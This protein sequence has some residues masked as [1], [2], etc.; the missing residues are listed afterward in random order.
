VEGLW[1]LAI[2]WAA[3][4]FFG[5]LSQQRRDQQ[6]SPPLPEPG[7]EPHQPRQRGPRH[8]AAKSEPVDQGALEDE[9]R[10]E[11]ERLLGVRTGEEY[12][13][14]GRT[15]RE[16]LPEAEDVE[17]RGSLEE[18][19]QA[20]SLETLEDRLPRSVTDFDDEAQAV[21]EQRLA[22]AEARTTGRT[23][24]DHR[25]FDQSIRTQAPAAAPP[26]RKR[27]PLRQ[28]LVWR[29]ILGP[30]VSLRSPGVRD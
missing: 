14:V 6:D 11:I 3:L 24:Q 5:R 16:R 10:R 30:P 4:S 2:I 7:R 22:V 23:L 20:V 13:P 19:P 29:E 26:V 21:L 28:A 12:G 9:W 27:P 25:R 1:I 18:E 17:E 8:R 15:A